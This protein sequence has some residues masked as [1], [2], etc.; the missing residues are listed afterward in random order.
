LPRYS[1]FKS[2]MTPLSHDS[3]VSMAPLCHASLVSLTL[4]SQN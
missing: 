3:M 2:S 1:S 4:L